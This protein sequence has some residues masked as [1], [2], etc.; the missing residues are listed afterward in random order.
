MEILGERLM[1]LRKEKNLSQED[2]AKAIEIGFNTYRRYE[3][4]S[5]EPG[6][7]TILALADF[8]GVS[9]DYLLGRTDVR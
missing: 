3:H 1:M 4:G 2:V 6:A 8:Y 7:S 5:R 9:A